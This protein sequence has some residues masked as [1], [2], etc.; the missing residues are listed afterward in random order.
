MKSNRPGLMK[1]LEHGSGGERARIDPQSGEGTAGGPT[2]ESLGTE[3]RHLLLRFIRRSPSGRYGSILSVFPSFDLA[4]SLCSLLFKC[5]KLFSL[6]TIN[7]LLT[8]QKLLLMC[9]NSA[10]PVVDAGDAGCLSSLQLSL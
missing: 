2:W 5:Y 10:K 1:S 3:G 4:I 9:I 8:H 7:S 6:L